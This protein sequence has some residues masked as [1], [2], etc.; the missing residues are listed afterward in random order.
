MR[1]CSSDGMIHSPM[2]SLPTEGAQFTKWENGRQR[3]VL[4]PDL[5]EVDGAGEPPGRGSVLRDER[6]AGDQRAAVRRDVERG[7][8]PDARARA[9]IEALCARPA[10]RLPELDPLVARDGRPR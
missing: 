1:S 4:F 6:A 3:T 10:V 9:A 2:G 8:G 7:R 5:P